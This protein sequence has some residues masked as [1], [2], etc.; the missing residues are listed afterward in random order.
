[1]GLRLGGRGWDR[2][3]VDGGGLLW[4][5]E[6]GEEEERKREEWELGSWIDGRGFSSL[7]LLLLVEEKRRK[8]EDGSGRGDR[9]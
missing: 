9:S 6:G 2:L 8:V 7:L 4:E 3:V 5:E 1:M